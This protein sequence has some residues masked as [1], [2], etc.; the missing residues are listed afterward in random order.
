MLPPRGALQGEINTPAGTYRDR[1]PSMRWFAL[2]SFSA[3]HVRLNVVGRERDGLVPLADYE[4]EID[5]LEADLR[6]AR[7]VR[8]GEPVVDDVIRLRAD[9]PLATDGPGAD[10]VVTWRVPSDA[11]EH[12]T[13]GVIGPFPLPRSGSHTPNGFLYVKGPGIPAGALD[14]RAAIDVPTTLIDL[15][16]WDRPAELSGSVIGIVTGVPR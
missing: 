10:V 15:L 9:D 14:E 11:V 13:T 1:W 7:D 8:T 16:G 3:G 4:R 2:P 6:R 12:P 5:E